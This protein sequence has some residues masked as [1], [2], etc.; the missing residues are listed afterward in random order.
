MM[1]AA[2]NMSNDLVEATASMEPSGEARI[3]AA[4]Q[5]DH[6]LVEFVDR[7]QDVD[8]K[9]RVGQRAG[10]PSATSRRSRLISGSLPL[11]VGDDELVAVIFA[12]QQLAQ[13]GHDEDDVV[14]ADVH[15][16]D[17]L[18]RHGLLAVDQGRPER[19]VEQRRQAKKGHQLFFA[20]AELL[21][22][23][24]EDI[25]S[26]QDLLRAVHAFHLLAVTR[27]AKQLTDL[28]R[29]QCITQRVYGLSL[30]GLD[31][32]HL[33]VKFTNRFSMDHI[34][35]TE[36]NMGICAKYTHNRT[37]ARRENR[38][39]HCSLWSLLTSRRGKTDR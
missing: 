21:I 7:A 39:N 36:L 32:S 31:V 34:R 5:R 35:Q 16:G 3:G 8:D 28:G 14:R 22:M 30:C 15:I 33:P 38:Q 18:A 9:L 2:P 11:R 27:G 23:A 20:L 37:L 24:H 1:V 4:M 26:E 10:A 17:N 13:L 25:I 12:G 6:A 29:L 19:D